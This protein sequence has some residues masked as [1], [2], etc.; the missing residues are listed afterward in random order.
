MYDGPGEIGGLL[1]LPASGEGAVGHA[2]GRHRVT[3]PMTDPAA[4]HSPE[5]KDRGVVALPGGG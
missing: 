2:Q 4:T 3:E 1:V 5:G